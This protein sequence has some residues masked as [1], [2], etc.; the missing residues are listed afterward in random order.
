MRKFLIILSLIIGIP[1]IIFIADDYFKSDLEDPFKVGNAFSYCYMLKNSEGMK[2]W[3]EKKIYKKIDDLQ[4][5][6]PINY[7]EGLGDIWQNFELVSCRKFG[8]TLVCTYAYATYDYE[9]LPYFYSVILKPVGPHSLWERFKSFVYF[10][11]PFGDIFIG[12]YTFGKTYIKE[13]WLAVDFFT[14]DDFQKY[15]DAF[16]E[17]VEKIRKDREGFKKEI[18]LWIEQTKIMV[19]RE[20]NFE[21][22]WGEREKVKQNEEIKKLYMDY[23]KYLDSNNK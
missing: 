3:A 10:K 20:K 5:S 18:K 1:S 22:K 19:E 14:N 17:D 13:R 8:A 12:K 2:L 16:K 23:L 6:T 9:N 7:F 15:V 11:V 21:D 4:Y